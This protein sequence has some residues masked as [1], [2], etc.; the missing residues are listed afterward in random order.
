MPKQTNSKLQTEFGVNLRRIRED[1][2]FSLSE[3]SSRCDVDKSNIAKIENGQ[4]NIQLTK[5]FELAKG[6]GVKPKELLDF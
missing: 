3:V 6:L 5:I 2:G 1:K 4:F